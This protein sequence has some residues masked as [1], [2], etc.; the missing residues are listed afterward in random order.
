VPAAKVQLAEEGVNV[1]VELVVKPTVPVGVVGLEEVSMTVAVQL[2]L[3]PTVTEL[4][5][6]ATLVVVVCR[7]AG[8]ADNRN[9]P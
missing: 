4:G 9:V 8:V 3:V 2:E 6:Q 5:E 1:P 7:G